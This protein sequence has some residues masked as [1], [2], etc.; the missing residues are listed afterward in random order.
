MLK[1]KNKVIGIWFNNQYLKLRNL[2]LYFIKSNISTFFDFEL[3]LF[4]T[5]I[6]ATLK[7]RSE[8]NRGTGLVP[9]KSTGTVPEPEFRSCPDSNL[10]L[11]CTT[12]SLKC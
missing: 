2:K 12:F 5:V 7:T 6:F 8:K 11:S 9:A 3:Y 4:S 10:T 1:Q